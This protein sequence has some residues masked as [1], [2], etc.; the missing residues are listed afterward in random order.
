VVVAVR[1]AP[2]TL[3]FGKRRGYLAKSSAAQETILLY[4][5]IISCAANDFAALQN[6]F[7]YSK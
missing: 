5:R 6:H 3:L 4:C 1:T 7:P 2:L